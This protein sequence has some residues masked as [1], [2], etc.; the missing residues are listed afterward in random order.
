VTNGK[1]QVW[2]YG[3]QGAAKVDHCELKEPT[4]STFASGT[5]Q[6]CNR[7]LD[8]AGLADSPLWVKEADW[9]RYMVDLWTVR[10]GIDWANPAPP[11]D[12]PTMPPEGQF[13]TLSHA[14]TWIAFGVSMSN[15]HLHEVLSQDRYGERDPQEAIAAALDLLLASAGGERVAIRGKY[16]ANRDDDAAKLH[17]V[18]I[19]AIKFADYRQFSYLE[20]ELRHGRGL[21]VG[22]TA[23]DKSFE[24]CSAADVRIPSPG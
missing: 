22:T 1:L 13:V 10:Y 5:Y 18:L 23:A 12:A 2:T 21:L 15:D 7:R 14:L 19:E 8:A 11:S 9:H 17:T 6:P 20:D 3:P 24:T 4:F 16:R